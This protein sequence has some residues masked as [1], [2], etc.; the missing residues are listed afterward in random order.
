MPHTDSPVFERRRGEVLVS[1]DP[2]RLDMDAIYA[3]LSRVYWSEGIPRETLER[4][5][6]NSIPFG[7]YVEGAQA[8]FA[9]VITDCATFAYLADVFVL[10][11]YRERGLSK[12]LM[13]A[14]MSHPD[15]QGLRRFSLATRD[16]H[17]LYRQFGFESPRMPERLMEIVDLDVYKRQR[18]AEADRMR[19]PQPQAPESSASQSQAPQS[20][21][22]QSLAE[23]G[24][25]PEASAPQSPPKKILFVC[26]GNTC[27]SPMAEGFA[28][29]F[30]QGHVRAW[31]AGLFP[32]GWIAAETREVMEE[33]GISLDGQLSKGLDD[34]PVQDMDLVV[35]MAGPEFTVPRPAGF[36]GRVI[37][38]DIPDAFTSGLECNR[39]TRDAI[40]AHVRA[41]LEELR[42]TPPSNHEGGNGV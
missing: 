9:R 29:H 28:N 33:K 39:V 21:T 4:A 18:A 14:I 41:L 19:A 2:A 7:V 25:T 38:W 31:S 13:E 3:F 30:G 40:E 11:S 8:G 15:L 20:R 16:A 27:R 37:Q 12:L 1:T 5:I 10:E 42:N 36:R 6:R 23:P 34:V 32:V 17:G 35:E 22:L 24:A 26:I